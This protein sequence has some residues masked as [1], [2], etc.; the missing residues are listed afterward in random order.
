MSLCT[1]AKVAPPGGTE[2]VTQNPHP[3]LNGLTDSTGGS[4]FAAAAAEASTVVQYPVFMPM[5]A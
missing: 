3:A 5:R 2:E 4:A 1:G